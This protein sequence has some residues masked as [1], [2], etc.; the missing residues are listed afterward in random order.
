MQDFEISIL[1]VLWDS[2]LERFDATSKTIQKIE[3]ELATCVH[4]YES[5]LVFVRSLR[6]DEAFDNFE[7]MAKL[8][9]EDYSYRAEHQRSRIRK[10]YFE[11]ANNEILMSPSQKT[12]TFYSILDSLTTE[13]MKKKVVYYKLQSKF[14]FLFQITT[15]SDFELRK[16]ASDLQ[17]HFSTDVEY[18]FV[19]ELIQFY[20]YM[21]EFLQKGAH[22]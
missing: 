18:S 13:L 2:I 17:K 15:L 5:L 11:E 14:G 20:G 8:L 10:R 21:K 6:N 9:V 3:I 19:E 7:E 16:A 1:C 4:L 22:P 12:T